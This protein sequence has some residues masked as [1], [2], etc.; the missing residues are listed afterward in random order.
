MASVLKNKACPVKVSIKVAESN[1][2]NMLNDYQVS[3]AKV[4]ESLK[5]RPLHSD[6]DSSG[7]PHTEGDLDHVALSSLPE[8]TRS[9]PDGEGWITI[10]KPLLYVYAGQGPYASPDLMQFP[11]SV[12]NDG[13]IDIAVQAVVSATRC[14]LSALLISIG[15]GKS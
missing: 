7:N 10:D 3:M 9:G 12:P 5:H 14:S 6:V 8:L 13:L 1:K 11:V 4:K 15:L 2:M